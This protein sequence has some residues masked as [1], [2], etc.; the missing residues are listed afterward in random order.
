MEYHIIKNYPL[1]TA[2]TFFKNIVVK[3]INLYPYYKDN[4]LKITRELQL[5]RDK[6]KKS[7]REYLNQV[8]IINDLKKINN[9]LSE[10]MKDENKKRSI[11][12]KQLKI[13]HQIIKEPFN[14]EYKTLPIN[15]LSNIGNK[16]YEKLDNNGKDLF[17]EL[18]TIQPEAKK[19]LEI[20]KMY[21]SVKERKLRN[22]IRDEL[23]NYSNYIKDEAFKY[24]KN[25]LKNY[26]IKGNKISLTKDNNTNIINDTKL[27]NDDTLDRLYVISNTTYN[28]D[29]M[30]EDD[31]KV[32]IEFENKKKGLKDI[33][34]KYKEIKDEGIKSKLASTLKDK[35]IELD[36]INDKCNKIIKSYLDE[37]Q[38]QQLKGKLNDLINKDIKQGY[39]L[40]QTKKGLFTKEEIEDFDK[41][42]KDYKD[43]KEKE[44]QEKNK[45][46]L[47]EKAKKD[48][49]IKDLEQEKIQNKNE[50][51]ET[52]I[53]EYKKKEISKKSPY[54]KDNRSIKKNGPISKTV[55]NVIDNLNTKYKGHLTKKEKEELI[56]KVWKE[57]NNDKEP[58]IEE[59]KKVEVNES[60]NEID[61]ENNDNKDNTATI[62]DGEEEEDEEEDNETEEEIEE[63]KGF[64]DKILKP[65]TLTIDELIKQIHKYYGKE[66]DK[67]LDSIIYYY[68]EKKPNIKDIN[69]YYLSILKKYNKK[70]NKNK[71]K[72]YLNNNK[73]SEE[74]IEELKKG[75]F[76]L[77]GLINIGKKLLG[78]N[79]NKLNDNNYKGCGLVST[80]LSFLGLNDQELNKSD[81]K[82]KEVFNLLRKEKDKNKVDSYLYA[83]CKLDNNEDKEEDIKKKFKELQ[84]KY[85]SIYRKELFKKRLDKDYYNNLGGFAPALL[86]LIPAGI[87]AIS[88]LIS[89]IS[90]AVRGKGCDNYKGGKILSLSQ[91]EELKNK[92]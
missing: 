32:F 72:Q 81:S 2:D 21:S 77:S 16:M 31:K 67:K 15:E 11:N 88:G 86:G 1:E 50:I 46:D 64:S 35:Y 33:I 9:V 38:K 4:I 69:K 19:V 12:L 8:N 55:M 26:I 49:E 90:N 39:I 58:I 52:I 44:K 89:S 30:N 79:D 73:Y 91:L 18:I 82:Y 54:N 53:T 59:V 29:N 76:F 68:V 28:T 92:L 85:D 3:L 87:S 75:G 43:K 70:Y 45:A 42:F 78:L 34:K 20:L 62:I 37:E 84:Y 22:I 10:L 83:I 25:K 14:K 80:V 41:L 5:Y 71:H 40:Y 74:Y 6:L 23:N 61:N 66:E 65:E 7:N 24:S 56:E 63:G 48:K 27:I 13:I 51:I 47:E 17:Y 36:P 60:D 57:Q